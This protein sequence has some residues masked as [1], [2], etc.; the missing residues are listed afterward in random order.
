MLF[1][2]PTC[3][4]TCDGLSVFFRRRRGSKGRVL[5]MKIT[6][7]VTDF[8]LKLG[9]TMILTSQIMWYQE[10][11]RLSSV[12]GD[13]LFFSSTGEISRHTTTKQL[14]KDRDLRWNPE[15]WFSTSYTRLD[16][17]YSLYIVLEPLR[18]PYLTQFFFS[19]S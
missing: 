10:G 7:V 11:L 15:V 3:P 12:W 9:K 2:R 13:L 5:S 16:F 8:I 4:T 18:W 14:C 19:E 17:T 6:L 1:H